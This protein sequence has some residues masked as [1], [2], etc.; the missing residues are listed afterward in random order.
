MTT[1]LVEDTT[2]VIRVRLSVQYVDDTAGRND[3]L[4]RNGA[5]LVAWAASGRPGRAGWA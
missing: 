4:K 1:P 2:Q 5:V 3:A